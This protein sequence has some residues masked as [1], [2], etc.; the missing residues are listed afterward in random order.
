MRSP[1]WG[2]QLKGIRRQ[3]RGDRVVKYHRATGI[4]LPD[5]PETH[6][7]FVA[8]WATAEASLKDP[9]AIARRKG[10]PRRCRAVKALSIHL[11]PR[12]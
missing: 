8:A 7:D 4:R 5:L 12:L 2:V 1:V 3:R 6:P 10:Q 11:A 9:I